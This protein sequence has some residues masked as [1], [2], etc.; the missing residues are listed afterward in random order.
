MSFR[1]DDAMQSGRCTIMY[2]PI[3]QPPGRSSTRRHSMPPFCSSSSPRRGLRAISDP[4]PY[5]F[6]VATV[7]IT[8]CFVPSLIV[9]MHMTV[10]IS[11]P[12]LAGRYSGIPPSLY[13][14]C[15]LSLADAPSEC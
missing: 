1:Q 10:H 11:L 8:H 6:P 7:P 5:W 13:V 4:L 15:S 2:L 12:D 14:K 9:A 3:G